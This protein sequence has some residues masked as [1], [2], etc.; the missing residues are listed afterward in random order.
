MDFIVKQ[1]LFPGGMVTQLGKCLPLSWVQMNDCA[2]AMRVNVG[3][4]SALNTSSDLFPRMVGVILQKSL[5]DVE[6]AASVEL[7]SSA[8]AVNIDFAK[9]LTVLLGLVS[10]FFVLIMFFLI[11]PPFIVVI[12]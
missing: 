12:S 3:A 9:S 11:L 2:E 8:I 6:T 5:N 7:I 10:T 4:M 1:M